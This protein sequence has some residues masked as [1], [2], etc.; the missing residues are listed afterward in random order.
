MAWGG[1]A[2]REQGE[3]RDGQEGVPLRIY[4]LTGLFNS[5]V[6]IL[7]S[8][9][10]DTHCFLNLS[11]TAHSDGAVTATAETVRAA[12]PRKHGSLRK[13]RLGCGVEIRHLPLLPS[14]TVSGR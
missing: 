5:L 2:D 10:G 12:R 8:Y 3:W 9:S 4:L 11:V 7:F 6:F 13:H 14:S 1:Q